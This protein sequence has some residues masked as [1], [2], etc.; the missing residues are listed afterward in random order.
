MNLGI[1]QLSFNSNQELSLIAPIL[2]ANGI[3]NIEIIPFKMDEYGK[4]TEIIAKQND[5][6]LRSSQS[7]LFGSDI[8]DFT[9]EEFSKYI[10]S[11]FKSLSKKGTNLFVLGSPGQR[12]I[13]DEVKLSEQ[14]RIIDESIPSN[15]IL[16]IEPNCKEYGGSYFFT[17]EEIATFI[18]KNRYSKIKTMIDTHNIIEEGESPSSVFEEYVD[19][20]YHVHVSENG[21]S[22]FIESEE[23]KKLAKSLKEYN[24]RGIVTYE[25]KPHE[26][27]EDSL[28]KFNL[29]Y[30]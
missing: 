17:V 29:I 12:K 22:P 8:K 21:L 24:Y 28:K 25:V 27:L 3:N 16:C 14:F 30:K 5:L 6:T 13:Y 11:L 19:L 15:C 1:S 7:I 10:I 23:H 4:E 9:D 18:R 20:I 2:K 26:T